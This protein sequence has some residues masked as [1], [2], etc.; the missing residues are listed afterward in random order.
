[1]SSGAVPFKE[2]GQFQ[3]AGVI[4]REIDGVLQ[5][6]PLRA[7]GPQHHGRRGDRAGP[8]QGQADHRPAGRRAVPV[9]GSGGARG[10]WNPA[11]YTRFEDERTRPAADLLAHVALTHP[12][13]IVD[14]GCGPGNSTALIARALTRMRR[15][16]PRHLGRHAG[17]R[18]RPPARPAFA[19]ADAADLGARARAGPDL[20]QRRRCN[21]CRTT[22]PCCRDCSA[23][24]RP[25]ASSP[26][27]CPTTSPSPRIA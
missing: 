10:D 20:R 22:R 15:D 12:A 18:P 26:C 27:R 17:E 13:P 8:R 14:L 25:A 4:E 19:Q 6:L 7:G 21:G 9:T 24:S 3:T 11:L 1:M 2:N 16:R 5:E 23:S